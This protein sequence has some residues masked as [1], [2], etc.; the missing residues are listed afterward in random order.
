M[1]TNT[2]SV[3]CKLRIKG[4]I[5]MDVQWYSSW[6]REVLAARSI[7]ACPLDSNNPLAR[8]DDL[9]SS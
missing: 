5:G 7:V 3:P 2:T 9:L 4:I 1:S 8:P 6:R